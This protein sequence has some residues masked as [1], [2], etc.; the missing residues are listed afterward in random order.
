MRLGEA[1][2]TYNLALNEIAGMGFRIRYLYEET[3]DGEYSEWL[4]ERGGLQVYG[5]NPL[6]LLALCILADKHGENWNKVPL[7]PLYDQILEES[8]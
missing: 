5:S 3:E 1:M 4:A 2:N 8:D 7:E 6:S